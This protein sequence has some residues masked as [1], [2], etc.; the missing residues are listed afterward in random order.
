M[1]T[2]EKT[3]PW[4]KV[5]L[6]LTGWLLWLM[7]HCVKFI[8]KS[9]Y[10][11]VALTSEN[12]CTAAWNGFTLMIKNAARYGMGTAIGTVFMVFGCLVIGALTGASAYFFIGNYPDLQATQPIPPAIVCGVIA[13]LIGM[14]FLSIFTFASDAIFQSFLLDEE[15]RF[16]GNNRPDYMQEFAEVF[17][18]RGKGGCCDCKCC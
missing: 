15:L 6:I 12:F 2:M 13:T 7:E 8:S 18:Q 9:A 11:Q 5:M 4:V 3:I 14:C 1:G 10:I 16:A 17:K